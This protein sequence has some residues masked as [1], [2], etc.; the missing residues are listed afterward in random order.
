MK[1]MVSIII[2]AYNEEKLLPDCL[3]SL[4]GVDYPADKME[5]IVVDN[6][7]SDRTRTIAESY[8][9]VVLRDDKRTVSGLRNM[10][11]EAARGEILA[12]VDADCMV[13]RRW[14]EAA[15]KYYDDRNVS[16]W[17]AAPGLPGD[18]TWVQSTWIIIRGNS[19]TVQ[20][21]SWLE[22]M[23]LFARRDTFRKAGGFNE[24]LHTCED[25][26]FCYRMAHYG[27]IV[28][29][30]RIEVIHLGEAATVGEFIAKEL[31]RGSSNLS[32]VRSHGLSAKEI[33][34]L[35]VPLYFGVF[36][37]LILF[38]VIISSRLDLLFAGLFYCFLPSTVILLKI[39][40]KELG[41]LAASRLIFLVQ[42]YFLSRTVAVF[43]K[44]KR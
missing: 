10:G 22:S 8:G 7:S 36:L 37:P 11:A 41:A 35:L 29:D 21:V 6:G 34:S 5:I 3:D 42:I 30:S 33:P 4:L 19:E 39:R 44:R 25:V 43:R 38:V 20:A 23:N 18:A 2:P 16:V 40:K 31:W 9:A 1:K 14:L 17:G 24:A 26:D 13:A 12:F 15:S 27:K 28:S 32:G